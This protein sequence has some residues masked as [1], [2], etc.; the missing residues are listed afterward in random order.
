MMFLL[1]ICPADDKT[2]V[3]HIDR[4]GS[5]KWPQEFTHSVEAWRVGKC[6]DA[7]LGGMGN[8]TKLVNTYLKCIC[9]F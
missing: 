9:K 5:E 2:V 7:F 4:V 8:V 1:R 3:L 6:E